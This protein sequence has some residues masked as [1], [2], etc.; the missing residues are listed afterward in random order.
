MALKKWDSLPERMRT[1]EVKPYYDSLSRRR[2]GLALKRIFDLVMSV[3]LIIILSPAMLV[4]AVAVALDSPGGV[5]YR[6]RR[7]TTYGK[8]FRIF[9]FRTMRSDADRIGPAVTSGEDARITRVGKVLRGCRLDELPQLFNVFCGDMSFVGT[10][11]EVAK[12]V[13]R[14][15][16]EM[17]A[18]LLMPAGITSEASIRF[19]DEA[20]MFDGSGDPEADYV[21]ILLPKKMVYNLASV[22]NFSPAAE[23]RTMVRTVLAVA[24]KDYSPDAAADDS[25]KQDG[26]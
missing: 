11:P 24:G 3:L 19:K 20:Q 21:N 2:A 22:M 15:T 5:F 6:Q 23:L 9:K 13:D 26:K 8:E 10:R 25:R 1:P 4:I 18:T 12:F 7:V 16:P 17:Y 14:Y